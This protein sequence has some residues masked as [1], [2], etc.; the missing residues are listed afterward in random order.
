MRPNPVNIYAR[1]HLGFFFTSGP[2]GPSTQVEWDL[3][4]TAVTIASDGLRENKI[5]SVTIRD[6]Y[7]QTGF[8]VGRVADA[9]EEQAA[10]AG[11]EKLSNP[12][13]A[14]AYAAMVVT[15]CIGTRWELAQKHK[16][17]EKQAAE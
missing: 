17:K 14:L 9:V 12:D 4:R 7:D 8:L 11:Y 15:A 10:K 13:A 1:N 3:L 16:E 6:G 5:R 2:E